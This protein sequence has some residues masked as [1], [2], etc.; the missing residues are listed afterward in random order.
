[1]RVTEQERQLTEVI[2]AVGYGEMYAVRL[3]A[4]PPA[5]TL[6]LTTS[7]AMRDLLELL[8]GKVS[9]I[10]VLTIHAGE[11]TLV[12]LDYQEHG[13]RCRKKIKLPTAPAEG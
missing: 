12:E 5:P 7:A 8:R 6:T 13:F 4:N 2:R 11:P 10:D 9:Q 3:G 1:M